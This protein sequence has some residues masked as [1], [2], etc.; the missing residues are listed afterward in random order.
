MRLAVVIELE[1]GRYRA[2]TYMVGLRLPLVAN[3]GVDQVVRE[4]I[5]LHQKRPVLVQGVESGVE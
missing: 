5:S 2:E 3:P 1:L 4:H